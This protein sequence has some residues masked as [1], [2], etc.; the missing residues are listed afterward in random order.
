MVSDTLKQRIQTTIEAALA[1]PYRRD[2]VIPRD[3]SRT[4]SAIGSAI[5]RHGA[6]IQAALIEQLR[7]SPHHVVI[8]CH[9]FPVTHQADRLA[10]DRAY[11]TCLQTSLPYRAADRARIIVPDS[12][13]LDLRTRVVSAYEIKRGSGALDAGKTRSTER[14]LLCLAMLAPSIV[15]ALGYTVVRPGRAFLIS[16]YGV[17]SV[18]PCLSLTGNDLDRHFGVP[19]Q[20]YLA[21]VNQLY[22]R[23]LMDSLNYFYAGFAQRRSP[24]TPWG[25]PPRLL[26]VEDQRAAAPAQAHGALLQ[27]P[28]LPAP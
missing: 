24:A 20:G 8:D 3:I 28:G 7:R 16:Y 10:E 21:E 14:D 26:P 27:P 12:L 6:I 22:R 4:Q 13:V 18:H 15:E 25:P 5:K 23:H 19:I 11:E 17:V 2:P 9:E 1:R